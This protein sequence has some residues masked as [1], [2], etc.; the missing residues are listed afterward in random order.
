[1]AK[2]LNMR[3]LWIA[4]LITL[5]VDQASKAWV[6]GPLNL[7]ERAWVEIVPPFLNF[8]MAWNTGV[9]FGLFGGMNMRWF[10]SG[11]AV[12]ICLLVLWW[13]IRDRAGRWQMAAA[14][15]LIGGAIGNVIDRV[16]FG[17]VVDFVNMSCC[18]IANPYAF[19]IADVGIFAGAL[20]LVLLS[21][22][23]TRKRA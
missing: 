4:A 8:H 22:P 14:G 2:R 21:G 19:N 6:L 18:G 12:A 23:D 7:P 16:R 20:G 11:L 9:N 15:L 5:I 17:A 1:M 3:P 13:V 10:L